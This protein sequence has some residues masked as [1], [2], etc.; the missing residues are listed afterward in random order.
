MY[1]TIS[2]SVQWSILVLVEIFILHYGN[3]A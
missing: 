2:K 1:M 3:V